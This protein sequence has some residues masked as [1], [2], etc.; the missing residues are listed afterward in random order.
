MKKAKQLVCLIAVVL[1]LLF[2]STVS[3]FAGENVL[4]FDSKDGKLYF[5]NQ[6]SDFLNTF[7][8]LENM[9]P[10]KVYSDTLYIKN[11]SGNEYDLSLQIA[12]KD[13]TSEISL[14]LLKSIG[15]KLIYQG[16]VIFEG[17]ADA[18]GN[19]KE[20]N[21]SEMANIGTF[22]PGE[23]KRLDVEVTVLRDPVMKK[24][25]QYFVKQ[26]FE[27]WQKSGSEENAQPVGYSSQQE[28][29][30]KATSRG[31]T[32]IVF[33]ETSTLDQVAVN[34]I[35]Q[36]F[37]ETNWNFYARSDDGIIKIQPPKTG[38]DSNVGQ[39]L[40]LAIVSSSIV[41]VLFIAGKKSKKQKT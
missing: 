36:T 19:A 27:E 1:C 5:E 7:L 21:L 12:P 16:K 2:S 40:I 6:K 31:L 4:K 22:L 13:G 25:G 32:G 15:M 29:T 39:Y 38:D 3:A 26:D 41:A 17:T 28:A 33:Y 30:E 23:E 8:H 9:V 14:E 18:I 37:G 34:E 10:G 20:M 24:S 35:F 11:E